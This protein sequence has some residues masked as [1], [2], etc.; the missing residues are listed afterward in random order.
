MTVPAPPPPPSTSPYHTCATAAEARVVAV[1][2]ATEKAQENLVPMSYRRNTGLPQPQIIMPAHPSP[3]EGNPAS[4][5]SRTPPP[6][7]PKP[8]G[9]GL[10]PPVLPRDPALLVRRSTGPALALL[11][12]VW[13][14][15]RDWP[16]CQPTYIRTNLPYTHTHIHTLHVLVAYTYVTFLVVC[17]L[18]GG[19]LCWISL[20]CAMHCGRSVTCTC[21]CQPSQ[22]LLSLPPP[23]SP[24]P[25]LEQ[26]PSL[27]AT[28][29]RGR[30][31]PSGAKAR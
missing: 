20:Q 8:P 16:G 31:A 22:S 18:H 26:V 10:G 19:D 6:Q 14:A 11:C 12:T 29:G 24:P 27:P 13:L 3:D 7:Y 25:P 4:A 9:K 28:R 30:P 15:C 2:K 23:P 17:A 5:A 1:Q 21:H